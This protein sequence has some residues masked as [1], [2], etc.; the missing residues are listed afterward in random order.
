MCGILEVDIFTTIALMLYNNQYERSTVWYFRSM[1]WMCTVLIVFIWATADCRTGE[2][3]KIVVNTS[4]M[5]GISPG[6]WMVSCVP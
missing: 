1:V 4:V 6:P 3:D 5:M 2:T